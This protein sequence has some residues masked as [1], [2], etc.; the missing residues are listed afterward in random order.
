MCVCVW[1]ICGM[2]FMFKNRTIHITS[3]YIILP[4]IT[5][6]PVTSVI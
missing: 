5:R 2:C 6:L 1:E 4:D 3:S